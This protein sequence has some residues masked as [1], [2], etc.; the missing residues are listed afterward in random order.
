[1]VSLE[2]SL[3]K[4]SLTVDNQIM[5]KPFDGSEAPYYEKWFSDKRV[6]KYLHPNTPFTVDH[7]TRVSAGEFVSYVSSTDGIFYYKIIY[8]GSL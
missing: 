2:Q 6:L 5:L 4:L 8:N 3:R 7:E 1:M